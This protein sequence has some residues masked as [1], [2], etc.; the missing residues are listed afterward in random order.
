MLVRRYIELYTLT[1]ELRFKHT[2]SINQNRV[3]IFGR[4]GSRIFDRL[5][6]QLG[7]GLS[8][9]HTALPV[10]TEAVLLAVGGV[11]HPVNEQIGD[12]QSYKQ[13]SVQSVGIRM[14]VGKIDGAMAVTQGN[15]SKVPEDKHKAP[16]FVIHIPKWW[17]VSDFYLLLEGILDIGR[18]RGGESRTM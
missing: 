11:P 9:G 15:A 18:G 17:H 8:L 16:F 5:P 2:P 12:V 4:D 14:M 7:E 10:L 6:G 13:I 1:A 3:A